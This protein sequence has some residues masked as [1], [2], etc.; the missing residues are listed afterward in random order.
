MRFECE[1]QNTV[2]SLFVELEQ[3]LDV[4]QQINEGVDWGDTLI[5]DKSIMSDFDFSDEQI[6]FIADKLG[7]NVAP[8]DLFVDIAKQLRDK[9]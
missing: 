9:K 6:A 2:T 3:V 8:N 5:T 7:V 4:F 1:D